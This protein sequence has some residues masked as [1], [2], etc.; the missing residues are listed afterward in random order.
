MVSI[1]QTADNYIFK[2]SRFHKIWALKSKLIIEK[3]NIVTA[4]QD[5]EELY[6]FKGFRIGTY[7][8]FLI[9]AGTFYWKGKRNFWDVMSY[10]NTIIVVLKNHIYDK[11]YIEVQNPEEALQLLNT[12]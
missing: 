1:E 2:L 4:Y 6:N 9:T 11:L 12:K 10:K 3:E 8:P 5:K 7:I